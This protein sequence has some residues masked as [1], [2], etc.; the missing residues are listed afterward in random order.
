MG[1]LVIIM[2]QL[3]VL[4]MLEK[5]TEDLEI[6]SQAL[7]DK[8]TNEDLFRVTADKLLRQGQKVVEDLEG[9]L[10]KLSAEM[11]QKKTENDACQAE[12]Q[13]KNEE[14]AGA[15]SAHTE[16]EATLISE[17]DAWNQEIAT[18]KAQLTGHSPICDHVKNNTLA[19]KLCGVNTTLTPVTK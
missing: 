12:K 13:T 10:A 1:L 6:K 8:I 9:T 17:S 14:L 15:E 4:G 7:D 11:E 16:T 5:A 3:Q 19:V 18:L 2:G